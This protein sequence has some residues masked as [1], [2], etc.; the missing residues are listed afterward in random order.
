MPPLS[1]GLTVAVLACC[2]VPAA[3]R[4]QQ[5]ETLAPSTGF[6]KAPAAVAIQNY[7]GANVM[8]ADSGNIDLKEIGAQGDYTSTYVIYD[9]SSGLG[10][11]EGMV[12]DASGNLFVTDAGAS[13]VRE[14]PWDSDFFSAAFKTLA[15]PPNGFGYAAG[16]A[17]DQ[18]GNVFVADY[19]DNALYEIPAAGGYASV[20]QLAENTFIE[21]W[22]VA[23]DSAG[24]VFVADKGDGIVYKLLA[25]GAHPYTIVQT[26]VPQ[27]VLLQP[28]G[29]AIDPQG[30]LYVADTGNNAVKEILAAGGYSTM[31]TLGGADGNFV[32]PQGLALDPSGNLYVADTG[33]SAI[34]VILLGAS[35]LAAAVLPGT[36][37]VETGTL[38]TVFATMINT[39]AN[40]LSGCAVSLGDLAVNGLRLDYQ[41][42][43]PATNAPTG[44]PNTPATIKAGASQ[45]FVLGFESNAAFAAPGM[46]LDFSCVD[47]APAPAI[48]GLD[49]IDLFYSATPSADVVAL[50]A[51]ATGDGIV[52]VPTGSSGAFAVAS[53]NL[54][55]GAQL[56]VTPDTGASSLPVTLTLCQT[57]SATAQCL[58]PP[59]AAVTL[60]D[61][62]QATPTFSIFVAASQ[63][64]PLAPA[65]ARIFVRFTD[66]SDTPR[67]STSV[68]VTTN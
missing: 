57:N 52:H 49:T 55:A 33:N 60:Q 39:G 40:D 61:S 59:S 17:L 14:V 11:L 23:V 13:A 50:S 8:V 21:P 10:P 54:G 15:K 56:T 3:A 41:T 43:N 62:P 32:G 22:G 30:N 47:A 48:P 7:F 26:V 6:F 51:T 34:K 67:G 53:V 42:T 36:R 2:L 24:N 58:A 46:A 63:P 68:A 29:L 65:T 35:P 18:A 64:I 9:Q 20:I 44:T 31:V 16:L 19:S 28:H 37:S 38:A 1:R 4:A 45:S 66:S 27:G 25:G 12:F 5:V